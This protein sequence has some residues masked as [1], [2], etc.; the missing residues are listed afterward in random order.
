MCEFVTAV[1]RVGEGYMQF[2]CLAGPCAPQVGVIQK[3]NIRIT[4]VGKGAGM[5][6]EIGADVCTRPG[7][8]ELTN[9]SLLWCREPR[10][11]F[12]NTDSI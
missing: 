4:K 5:S 11:V 8:Q 3:T 2:V 10:S 1:V 6:W 7:M 9:D 12:P